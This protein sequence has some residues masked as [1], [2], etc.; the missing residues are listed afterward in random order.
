MIRLALFFV[1]S[2]FLIMALLPLRMRAMADY[3]HPFKAQEEEFYFSSL[4][5]LEDLKTKGADSDKVHRCM[6]KVAKS[7]T[8]LSKY[9]AADLILKDVM[10]GRVSKTEAYDEI[11]AAAMMARAALRREV[12]DLETS[13]SLYAQT[14]DYGKK[15]LPQ[16][17]PRITRDK[18]NLAVALLV[19]RA[20]ANSAEKKMR[21]LK[22]AAGYLLEAIDE[23]KARAPQGSMREA[24][25]RQDL[26][27]ALEGMADKI[28]YE[29]ELQLARE[30]QSRFMRGLPS[31]EP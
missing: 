25:L 8:V 2:A 17:D 7:L 20:S 18:T 12:S 4:T 26:A 19:A 3:G 14:L 6:I 29:K 10:E 23:Q 30:M 21:Y 27:Y 16:G 24:N 22:T 11:F 5:E 15:H 1:L 13:I 9:P 31:K 28:G